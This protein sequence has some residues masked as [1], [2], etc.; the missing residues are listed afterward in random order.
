MSWSKLWHSNCKEDAQ[1]YILALKSVRGTFKEIKMQANWIF[2][3][4]KVDILPK[5]NY[6][7]G[8]VIEQ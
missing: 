6:L 2:L 5:H 1:F 7:R 3:F 4:Y 8:E